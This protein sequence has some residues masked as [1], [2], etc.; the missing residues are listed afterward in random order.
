MPSMSL[1]TA[2][3]TWSSGLRSPAFTNSSPCMR[4]GGRTMRRLI[5]LLG[6]VVLVLA[7]RSA[8]AQ[9]TCDQPDFLTSGGYIFRTP[10]EN[11]TG[12]AHGNFAVA[13]ACR[14][15]GDGKGSFGHLGYND[16]NAA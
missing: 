13:G 12:T 9:Q 8:G 14:T 16:D 11:S 3:R 10:P 5:S 1:S 15:G 2:S 4:S 7:G 6:A